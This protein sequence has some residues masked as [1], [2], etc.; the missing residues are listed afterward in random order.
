M[1]ENRFCMNCQSEAFDN[2]SPPAF[3]LLFSETLSLEMKNEFTVIIGSIKNHVWN[4]ELFS[5]ST[6]KPNLFLKQHYCCVFGGVWE[7]YSIRDLWNLIKL[8]FQS[9]T[10]VS[11]EMLCLLLKRKGHSWHM[12]DIWKILIT[13]TIL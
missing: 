1:C 8:L 5:E 12:F 10:V 4:P 3:H 6:A 9:I 13:L 11:F 2:I 7:A